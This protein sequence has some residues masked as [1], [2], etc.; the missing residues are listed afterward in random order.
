MKAT[1]KYSMTPEVQKG[2]LVEVSFR[3]SPIQVG[4]DA[5][6]VKK[7]SV[8]ATVKMGE[9]EIVRGLVE[10]PNG[11]TICVGG[12]ELELESD[13]LEAVLPEIEQA[14]LRGDEK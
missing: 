10:K 1:I 2:D 11:K 13:F 4:T 5:N 12:Y 14:S 3:C 6:I 7:P 9:S 8:S